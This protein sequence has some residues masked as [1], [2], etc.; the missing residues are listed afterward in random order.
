MEWAIRANSSD[1]SP[2]SWLEHVKWP[3][4]IVSVISKG[5]YCVATLF[6]FFSLSSSIL[7]SRRSILVSILPIDSVSQ[8]CQHGISLMDWGNETFR[9]FLSSSSTAFAKFIFV[10]W[11]YSFFFVFISA[12]CDFCDCFNRPFVSSCIGEFRL[13]LISHS[14]S[15]HRVEHRAFCSAPPLPLLLLTSLW[16]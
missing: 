6:L 8:F 5:F 4:R 3:R 15:L 1:F 7:L 12:K 9:N 13:L 2:G 16:L 11:N 14:W 10:F